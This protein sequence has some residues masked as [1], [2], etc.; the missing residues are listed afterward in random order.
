MGKHALTKR[1]I[2]KKLIFYIVCFA[3]PV[4]QFLIFY[5]GVNFQSILLAFQKYDGK[6]ASFYF[7][8]QDLWVNFQKVY[9]ELTETSILLIALKN[10][11][12]L[13]AA[14]SIVGTVA[15]AFFSY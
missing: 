9:Y 14:T 6:T 11:L 13:W 2:D 10:S 7:D 8:A 15:A 1:K 12:I 3:L 5:V 4:V